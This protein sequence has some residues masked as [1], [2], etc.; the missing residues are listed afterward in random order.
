MSAA[1]LLGGVVTSHPPAFLVPAA[2][3][4]GGCRLCRLYRNVRVELSCRVG[5]WAGPLP[6]CGDILPHFPAAPG[7]TT[8][9]DDTEPAGESVRMPMVPSAAACPP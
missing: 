5:P 3:A 4:K 2:L 1:V 8:P 9:P 6:W 7:P